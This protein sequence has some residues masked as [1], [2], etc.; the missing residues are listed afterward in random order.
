M[1][2]PRPSFVKQT[3]Q[4]SKCTSIL[5]AN[6]VQ[7]P[8]RSST[9]PPESVSS[10]MY[11]SQLHRKNT[12]QDDAWFTYIMHTCLHTHRCTTPLPS[13]VECLSR[14]RP[15]VI[16]GSTIT[17]QQISPKSH[18][19]HIHTD[20]PCPMPHIPFPYSH[21]ETRALIHISPRAHTGHGDCTWHRVQTGF[22]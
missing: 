14:S 3:R 10:I 9:S 1:I 11:V 20:T 7:H 12:P 15:R 6:Q 21:R 18:C 13:T 16:S 17:T 5:I 2:A 4:R 8:S 22:R 19:T